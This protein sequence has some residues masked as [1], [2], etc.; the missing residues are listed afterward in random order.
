MILLNRLRLRS[1][2]WV[3]LAPLALALAACSTGGQ[4]DPA[5]WPGVSADETQAYVA[6]GGGVYAVNLENGNEEWRY[7]REPS[8]DLSFYAAPAIAS[9]NVVYAGA[10]DGTVRAIRADTGEEIRVFDG[11][12]GRIVGS[13]VVAGDLLLVPT[14]SGTLYA[15]NRHSGAEVWQ[16]ALGGPLWSAPRVDGD[17]VYVASLAH[18]LYAI[19]LNGGEDRWQEAA[20]LGYAIADTPTLQDGSL[21]TGILGDSLVAL[22]AIDGKELWRAPSAGWL[23]GSPAISDGTAFF[24]DVNGNV[25]ALDLATGAEVWKATP[26][27]GVTSSPVA[28]DG[29]LVVGF[30]NGELM[31]FDLATRNVVWRATAAGPIF[32]DPVVVGGKVL[33]AVTAQQALLQAFLPDPAYLRQPR[34]WDSAGGLRIGRPA[35]TFSPEEKG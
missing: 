35:W 1:L 24:G 26:G 28:V 32:T 23:W 15:L 33:V 34:P 18:T 27:G 6:F 16:R 9:D 29:R 22:R 31:A 25:Y 17:T 8:R 30:E 11:L 12:D 5:S 20:D 4:T 14:H 7:P 3:L 10:Y 13:P 21:L 19:R 2:R